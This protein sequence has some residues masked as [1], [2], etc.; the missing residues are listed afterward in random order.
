MLQ[1]FSL[2]FL[3]LLRASAMSFLNRLMVALC[4]VLLCCVAMGFRNRLVAVLG[5]CAAL[6]VTVAA[7]AVFH[8]GNKLVRLPSKIPAGAGLVR[9]TNTRW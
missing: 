1:D 6:A 9:Q 8:R 2:S 3:Q 5:T 4:T 7:S